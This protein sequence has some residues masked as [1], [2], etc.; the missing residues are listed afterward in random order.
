MPN[1]NARDPNMR[2]ICVYTY[3]WMDEKDVRRVR[4]ELREIGIARKIPYKSDQDTLDGKYQVSGHTR[5][6]KYYE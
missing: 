3:D 5:I 1:P 6:S 2:V 4:E